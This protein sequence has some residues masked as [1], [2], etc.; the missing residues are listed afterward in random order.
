MARNYTGNSCQ[1]AGKRGVPRCRGKL[2][3]TILD[4]EDSLPNEDLDRA[5]DESRKADL[6]LCLGTSLQIV[7]S[8]RLPLLTLKNETGRLVIVN[9]Q[10]AKYHNKADLAIHA[11]VDDVMERLM[12]LLGREIPTFDCD[13]FRASVTLRER[14][15]DEN[16]SVVKKQEEREDEAVKTEAEDR[17]LKTE[18]RE[19]AVGYVKTEI[20]GAVDSHIRENGEA[21]SNRNDSNEFTPLLF[22][23]CKDL[24]TD[25]K[26]ERSREN[27]E[28]NVVSTALKK[29]KND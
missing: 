29:L 5:E 20:E 19:T 27:S 1:A 15:A 16:C 25:T 8:G 10:K 22:E 3:D 2:K 4:W 17:P 26:R 11:Y 18:T 23:E 13:I 7:P 24:K 6:A 9:L 14:S 12:T 21:R 28:D